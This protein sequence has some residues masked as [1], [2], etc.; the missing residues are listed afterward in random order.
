MSPVGTR[1][2]DKKQCRTT[3]L[4][5]KLKLKSA[6]CLFMST[7]IFTDAEKMLRI[8]LQDLSYYMYDNDL[9]SINRRTHP[10]VDVFGV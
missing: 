2:T 5:E 1:K 4:R 10:V 7:P 6:T 3:F 8:E 9:K